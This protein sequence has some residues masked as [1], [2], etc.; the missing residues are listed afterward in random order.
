[1]WSLGCILVEMH[2]GEPLFSGSNEFDQLNKIIEV[3]GL[4]P[5]HMLRQA[6]KTSKYF[7]ETPD[8][9]TF[10]LHSLAWSLA[11]TCT[12]QGFSSIIDNKNN[13]LSFLNNCFDPSFLSIDQYDSQI[14]IRDTYF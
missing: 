5:K 4:P 6:I 11:E 8:G 10:F 2:T 14:K 12:D 13:R 7:I 9:K 3:C 1:M